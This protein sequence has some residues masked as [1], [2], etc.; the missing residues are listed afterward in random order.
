MFL[1]VLTYTGIFPY[2]QHHYGRV[3]KKVEQAKKQASGLGK[4]LDEFAAM[5]QTD[6]IKDA[7]KKIKR[8]ARRMDMGSGRE[9]DVRTALLDNF[10]KK[11]LTGRL[12]IPDAYERKNDSRSTSRVELIL[13]MYLEKHM[14]KML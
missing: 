2:C 6:K 10:Y 5:S 13:L 11:N 12:D 1:L 7:I 3:Q 14:V 4:P 9:G 8:E